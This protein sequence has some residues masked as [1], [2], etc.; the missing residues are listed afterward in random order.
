MDHARGPDLC[1]CAWRFYVPARTRVTNGTR[2]MDEIAPNGLF[3]FGEFTLDLNRGVLL[4]KHDEVRLRRR[5]FDVLTYLV[6][7]ARRLIPKQE[8]FDAL[9]QDAAVTDDSLVQCLVEIRKALGESH[10]WVRTVRGR[11]YMFDAPVVIGSDR[12][13]TAEASAGTQ[14][15]G[16]PRRAASR[17]VLWTIGGLALLGL[18]LAA[19]LAAA[20]HDPPLAAA[21]MAVLPIRYAVPDPSRAVLA[22]GLH[23]E[24][25]AALGQI[26]GARLRVLSRRATMAY[27]GTTKSTAEIG[28]ELGVEYLVEGTIRDNGSLWRLTFTV[29]QARDQVEAWRG[30]FDRDPS[31]LADIQTELGRAVARQIHLRLSPEQEQALVRRQGRNP[32]AHEHYLRGQALLARSN[33]VALRAAIDEFS[34]AIAL[35]PNYA[36]A[37]AGL[38]IAYAALPVTSDVPPRDVAGPARQAA[39]RAVEADV[40][41][42]EAH[43]ALGW[44]EF[45]FGWNWAAAEASLRRAVDLD[46]NNANAHRWLG[47]VLSNGGQ[48]S[49]ALSE[50][51]RARELDPFGPMQYMLS[52]QFAYQALDF[53]RAEGLARQVVAMDSNFWAGHLSLGQSLAAQGRNDE[54]LAEFTEALR[55]SGNAKSQAR[56]A[57]ALGRLGRAD[58]AR[59]VLRRL[60]ESTAGRFIPPYEIAIAHA[61][62][63]EA[64]GVFAALDQAYAVRDANLVFL[65]VDPKL[66]PFRADARY[67]ALLARCGFRSRS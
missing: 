29:V 45:W 47:H 67:A 33:W 9:W 30:T 36:L 53:A 50:V 5:T 16:T 44:Q 12:P 24:V 37:H 15:S 3:R 18:A 62:L 21:T 31:S 39:M 63:G 23:E 26:D 66:E 32:Q 52:S 22:E 27:A 11:G 10:D 48:H 28:R 41:L 46:P 14:V 34:H 54:A 2:I 51:A 55:L 35:D 59:E 65:P 6:R 20:R 13:V 64:D 19:W 4:R 58:E 17:A 40:L 42:A 38:S 7:N 60:R 57:Y 25:V 61:G 8:L 49:E 56:R 43:A 1:P